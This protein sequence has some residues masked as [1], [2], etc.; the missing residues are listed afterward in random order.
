MT[1]LSIITPVFNGVKFIELCIQSVIDQNCFD[2]EHIIVDG[3]S[4][5]GTIE[6]IKQYAEKYPHIY[7]ISELDKGQ[8]DAMNKGIKM[9]KGNIIGIL[10]VDDIYEK[11][12]LSYVIN[13]FQK[14]SEPSFLVGNCYVWNDDGTLKYINKPN[15]PSLLNILIGRTHLANPSAYFYHRSLHNKIGYYKLDEQYAMDTDFIIRVALAIPIKYVNINFGNFRMYN[16][17]K[18]M[19]DLES[20]LS[21]E[22]LDYYL[23]FYSKKLPVTHQI[24]VKCLRILR[25][26]KSQI[27]SII[28]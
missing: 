5:D 13:Y 25:I 16:E 8:S 22:R 15:K 9:A 12:T 20:G 26:I 7:W 10:N 24:L 19:R 28:Y 11:K 18:T 17:T 4:S 6:I 27:L 21:L 23:D 1:K 3:G 14:L 2:I